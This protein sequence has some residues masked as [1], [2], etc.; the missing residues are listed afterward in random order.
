MEMSLKNLV[1][2]AS[3]ADIWDSLSKVK[4]KMSSIKRLDGVHFN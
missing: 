2:I 4:E 3:D 1:S